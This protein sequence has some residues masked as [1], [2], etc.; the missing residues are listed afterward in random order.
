[1]KTKA[2]DFTAEDKLDSQSFNMVLWTGLKGEAQ[3][4]PSEREGRD[5]SK[6]RGGLLR[7]LRKSKN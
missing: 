1:D 3:P 2:F 7:E 4:Y 5:L 6:H